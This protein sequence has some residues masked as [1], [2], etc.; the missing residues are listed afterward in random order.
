M[1]NVRD[2]Q[3]LGMECV[4]LLEWM[5]TYFQTS[6][7]GSS[8]LFNGDG[9]VCVLSPASLPSG[10]VSLSSVDIWGWMVLCCVGVPLHCRMFSIP[11]L[12]PLD[13]SSGSPIFL[14]TLPDVPWGVVT[15]P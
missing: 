2:G 7:P 14:Q 13:V 8:S 3:Q 5:R 12:F 6:L 4:I 11:A 9:M 15:P 1:K 10:V